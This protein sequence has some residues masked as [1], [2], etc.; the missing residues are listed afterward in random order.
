MTPRVSD[1]VSGAGYVNGFHG[2]GQTNGRTD[3]HAD[4]LLMIN[5][6]PMRHLS[7]CSDPAPPEVICH[8]FSP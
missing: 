5:I 2:N 7:A 3:E 8:A 6:K 4:V 1:C